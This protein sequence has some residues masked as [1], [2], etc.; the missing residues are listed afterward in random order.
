M[1]K[2]SFLPSLF[3]EI[4][5]KKT[6]ELDIERRPQDTQ[7]KVDRYD[8]VQFDAWSNSS[9]VFGFIAQVYMGQ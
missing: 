6:F 5:M 3:L 2:I 4:A 1:P 9:K 8:Y 7:E